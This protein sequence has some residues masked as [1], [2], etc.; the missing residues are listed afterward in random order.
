[1]AEI[2][3]PFAEQKQVKAEIVDPFA[4]TP[5]PTTT[6]T[7]QT[8]GV[9]E[10]GRKNPNLYGAYGAGRE[11]LRTGIETTGT[12]GGAALGAMLP[13]PG[14]SL[15]GGGAGFATSKR[16]ANALLG[17]EVDMSGGGIAKD[18]AIGGLLQGA[19]NL[20][21]KIPI[22][23]KILS[24]NT[25]SIGAKPMGSGVMDKSAYSVAE[26]AL[27]VPPSG[28]IGGVRVDREKAVNTLLDNNLRVS[29]GGLNRVKNTISEL[30]DEFDAVV[31]KN[32]DAIIKTDSVL[33]PVN[34]LKDWASKTVNGNVYSKKIQSVI[35]NFKKQY[36]DEITVAQAQEIK[37]N[38]N[39][40]LK[41]SYGELKP[42][43][44]EAQKQIVRG[45]KDRIAQEIPE[46]TGVNLKYSEM[47]NLERVLERAVN[48][49]GNWDWFSLSAGMAGSIV[50]GATG[51]IAKAGEAVALWRF[52]KS[53]P[54]QSQLAL[55]LKKMGKG[56][57]ANALAN[58]IA[59]GVYHKMVAEEP[60]TKEELIDQIIG[61]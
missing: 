43:A 51:S 33:S 17:D 20:I 46:I 58:A 27:K 49:T 60:Q 52:L 32:P 23:N 25:A 18:V 14:T 50:G 45:L 61:K 4:P 44:E 11:L 3:D 38:T 30:N 59:N 2:I 42:V 6:Q 28:V 56:K 19:G 9:P 24:P 7:A 1:M 10:W 57:E 31:A 22:I 29:K 21:G 35:D 34:E 40:F 55:T 36:G 16:V 26:K 41:K 5:Q 47:K 8:D 48:R 37:R 12:T 39:A 13:L 54:V 15:L 53:P